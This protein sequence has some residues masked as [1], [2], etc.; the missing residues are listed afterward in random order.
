MQKLRTGISPTFAVC[1]VMLVLE[2][3]S[4]DHKMDSHTAYHVMR[5]S[6]PLFVRSADEGGGGG[7]F[8]G[9]CMREERVAIH[10]R[11]MERDGEK[12]V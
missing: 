9:T 10:V 8:R 1:A 12:W 4:T 6:L 7:V 2:A 3:N 11:G 5:W